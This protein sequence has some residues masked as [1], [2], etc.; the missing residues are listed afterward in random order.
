MIFTDQEKTGTM[1]DR[2]AAE[3]ATRGWADLAGWLARRLR[4]VQKPRPRL[5]VIERIP[6][7]PR[8][9]LVLVE[10]EGRRLL[11]ST[12]AEAGAQFYSLDPAPRS[13]AGAARDSAGRANRERGARVSW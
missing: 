7:A 11:V 8:Q 9:S 5:A 3:E 4:A 13:A 10:A 6:L 12:S 1:E 2:Q